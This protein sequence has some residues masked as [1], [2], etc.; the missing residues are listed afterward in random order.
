M[1]LVYVCS[2]SKYLTSRN[3][4]QKT[5]QKHIKK[6]QKQEVIYKRPG[7]QDVVLICIVAARK[8]DSE[9]RSKEILK[10]NRDR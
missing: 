3:P 9:E 4:Q 6:V 10:M 5:T 7:I 2:I 1:I 8:V